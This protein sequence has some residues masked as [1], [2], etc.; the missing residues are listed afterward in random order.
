M[1]A[2]ISLYNG[3]H[4]IHASARAV[5][6]SDNRGD[7]DTVQRS[8]LGEDLVGHVIDAAELLPSSNPLHGEHQ[9]FAGFE[10]RR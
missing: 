4:D 7:V 6:P 10:G 2:R 5:T 1:K 8:V 3:M 9:R